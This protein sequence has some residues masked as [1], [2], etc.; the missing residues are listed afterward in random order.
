MLPALADGWV[1]MPLPNNPTSSKQGYR[2]TKKGRARHPPRSL[3][4]PSPAGGRNETSPG[5][6][7]HPGSGDRPG[8]PPPAAAG[9]GPVGP[10]STGRWRHGWGPSPNLRGR[11]QARKLPSRRTAAAPGPESP[12]PSS[13]AARIPRPS[14]SHGIPGPPVIQGQ[15][16]Q[17]QGG[18]VES[19]GHQFTTEV[20]MAIA[21]PDPVRLDR[22]NVA[23]DYVQA[24]AGPEA[25]HPFPAQ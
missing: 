1:E 3:A 12:W 17:P 4:V 8:K 16:G 6:R 9:P 23:W 24:L 21:R 14:I 22:E 25:E 11:T 5:G 20:G 15:R 13:P 10:S 2:L 19:D 18:K 7:G